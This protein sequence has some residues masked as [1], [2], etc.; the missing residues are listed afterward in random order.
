MYKMTKLHIKEDAKNQLTNDDIVEKNGKLAEKLIDLG[1]ISG[2]TWV[3]AEG[4]SYIGSLRKEPVVGKPVYLDG[5]E[6]F[7][8]S[9]VVKIEPKDEKSWLITTA[10]SIYLLENLNH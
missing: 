5:N 10:N 2:G 6:W 3:I 9:P 8:S 1:F 7:R 4:D